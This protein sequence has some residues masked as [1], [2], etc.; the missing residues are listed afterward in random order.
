MSIGIIVGEVGLIYKFIWLNGCLFTS[1]GMLSYPGTGEG[2][3][4][5]DF[6]M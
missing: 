1:I 5:N 4:Q 3:E 6:S 2:N